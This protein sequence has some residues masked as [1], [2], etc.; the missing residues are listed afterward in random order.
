MGHLRGMG[1]LL[2]PE[3]LKKTD[4]NPCSHKLPTASQLGGGL[5]ELFPHP[6]WDF[7]WFDLFFLSKSR[8]AFLKQ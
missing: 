1:G 5:H 2:G 4:L 8:E 3:S 6:H 7:E